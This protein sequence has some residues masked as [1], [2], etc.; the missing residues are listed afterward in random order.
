MIV[1]V[2]ISKHN[3]HVCM[4]YCAGVTSTAAY[5]RGFRLIYLLLDD[6]WGSTTKRWTIIPTQPNTKQTKLLNVGL[7]VVGRNSK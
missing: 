7:L 4:R 1:H 5:Y 3:G 2:S 6:T